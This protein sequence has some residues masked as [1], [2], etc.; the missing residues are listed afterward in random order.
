VRLVRI[1]FA[2]LAGLLASTTAGAQESRFHAELRVEGE[3]LKEDCGQ[4]AVKKLTGCVITLVTDHPLHISL[5]S[6]AP[7]NGFGFGPAIVTHYTPNENWRLGWNSDAVVA[8]G[9]AWRA[10][11]YF[12]G[13]RTVVEV[14][15]VV[16]G[17]A[18]SA[19]PPITIHEYPVFNAYAQ[20]ISLP[21]VA[22][23][24]L[25]PASARNQR[26]LYGLRQAI[27]G[28]S[29]IVPVTA[30]AVG[31]LGLSVIGELNLRMVDIRSGGSGAPSIET[32]FSEATAPGLTSQP[33]FVQFGEGARLAPSLFNGHA[34][35]NYLFQWQQFVASDSASSFR[36][37]TVDLA[38]EVPIYRT[39]APVMAR[40]TNGPNE[41]ATGPT[42][43]T[44]PPISHDRW[45][46]VSFR[47]LIAKSGVGSGSAVP[48]YFMQTLGGSDINGN[49]ALPSYEDYRFRGPHVILFQ[50]TFEHSL[51]GPIGLFVGS[52]QGKVALQD[53]KLDLS[54][55]RH[56]V[57]LGVT[58]RA[59]GF[60]AVVFSYANGGSEGHHIAFTINTSLLGGSARPSL[61]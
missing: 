58:L 4:F 20:V 7:Q 47:A 55:L 53:D 39:S 3:H 13:V 49:R 61:Y 25:G 24:G 8:P 28:S 15:R 60:P 31:R 45:G 48:F 2:L 11:T 40:A 51:Y 33:T 36:R 41:C 59:G 5:G 29:A 16:T 38:H 27:V 18:A 21:K 22:F 26:T 43:D 9:G 35:L 42:A 32:L 23:F 12:K 17:G 14:P 6:I 56:S 19:A 37:W 30:G 46:T 52:D 1:A 57:A 34:R 44:C 50:E 54:D 10:G